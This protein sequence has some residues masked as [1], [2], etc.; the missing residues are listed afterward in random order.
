MAKFRFFYAVLALV[1]MSLPIAAQN[2][3]PNLPQFGS[4]PEVRDRGPEPSLDSRLLDVSATK[5]MLMPTSR[6]MLMGHN[7]RGTFRIVFR[8]ISNAG[9]VPFV[10][11]GYGGFRSDYVLDWEAFSMAGARCNLVRDGIRGVDVYSGGTIGA[12]DSVRSLMSRSEAGSV[13][14]TSK[15][16]IVLADFDCDQPLQ[17]GDTVTVQIK[18]YAVGPNGWRRATYSFN[19]L[20]IGAPRVK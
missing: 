9:D 5:P 13:A 6:S 20:R 10:T 17:V 3:M 11:I 19:E 2:T 18:F 16:V 4:G 1:F 15:P 7:V 14:S 8:V 12:A